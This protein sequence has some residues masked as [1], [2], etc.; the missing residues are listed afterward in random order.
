M[1][2]EVPNLFLMMSG[3]KSPNPGE[4]LASPAMERTLKNCA[5]HFDFVVLDSAPLSAGIRLARVCRHGATVSFS[6][7]ALG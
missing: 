3:P 5:E 6:S 1:R 7:R 2:T 4:L